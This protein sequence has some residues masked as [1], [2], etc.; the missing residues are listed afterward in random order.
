VAAGVLRLLTTLGVSM[1]IGG[2]AWIL[3]ISLFNVL[4]LTHTPDWVRAR[5]LA[6]SMLV[7]QGAMAAGSATWGVVATRTNIHVALVCAGVGTIATTALG[8]FLKLPDATVDLTPW[9]HWRLPT[10]LKGDPAADDAGPILVTVEYDVDPEQKVAFIKA[11][12]KYGRIRRRD[13]AY[14]WGVFQDL[15]KPDRYV[16]TFLVDS[17]AEHARQHERVTRADREMEERVHSYVR[18]SPTVRHLVY[19]TTRS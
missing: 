12:H 3:F 11:M 19:M 9:V 6:V 14:R 18:G 13:G 16:E 10:I 2:A 15:E 17:W 1:L 4:I 7:F 8:L 5:V